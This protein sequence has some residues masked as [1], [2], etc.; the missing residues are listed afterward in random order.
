MDAVTSWG[1]GMYLPPIFGSALELKMLY[2]L[3]MSLLITIYSSYQVKEML[4][5][6]CSQSPIMSLKDALSAAYA[7]SCIV[8]ILTQNIDVK[9]YDN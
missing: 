5:Y 3:K 8:Q 1:R 6:G 2:K 4:Q 9:V 7:L